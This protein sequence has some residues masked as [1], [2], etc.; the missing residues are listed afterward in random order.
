MRRSSVTPAEWVRHRKLRKKIASAKW[1][2]QKKQREIEEQH[3]HRLHIE[4]TLREEAARSA[5]YLWPDQR[6]RDE[7]AAVVAHH[8]RGFPVRPEHRCP[9]LWR[10]WCER[11]ERELDDL[12]EM[13]ERGWPELR[14]WLR[15]TFVCKIV[16]Q[17]AMRETVELHET[18][19]TRF[20]DYS[21]PWR[22]IH[23]YTQH[24]L[25]CTSP[26]NW[27]WILTHLGNHRESFQVVWNHLHSF[28]WTLPS[29]AG[30]WDPLLQ[31]TPLRHWLHWMSQELESHL[32]V[33]PDAGSTDTESS[34]PS[35][36]VTEPSPNGYVTQ[37]DTPEWELP[38]DLWDTLTD[39]ENESLPSSL[40][41]FLYE[42]FAH[43]TCRP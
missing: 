20:T 38:E 31:S 3:R 10:T 5:G 25:W 24:R 42:S 26:W 35:S 12:R 15:E 18:G 41:T 40:D 43:P 13:T 7:W 30:Q 1:Y 4:Q 23:P 6:V 21:V 34:P 2:A 22:G 14:P 17:L 33:N 36:Q 19:R 32:Q 27:I 9:G 8:C 16:R 29:D 39:S 28:A 11:I 37:P